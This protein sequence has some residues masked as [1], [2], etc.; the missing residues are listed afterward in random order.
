MSAL[1]AMPESQTKI[2][3]TISTCSPE[4]GRTYRHNAGVLCALPEYAEK[5]VVPNVSQQR[6]GLNGG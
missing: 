4:P 5:S 6:R 1:P 3:E 2:G